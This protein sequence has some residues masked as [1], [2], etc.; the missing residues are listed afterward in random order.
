MADLIDLVASH[1]DASTDFSLRR[2][3]AAYITAVIASARRGKRASVQLAEQ[4]VRSD[5]AHAFSFD[6]TGVATL[7]ADGKTWC[8]GRFQTRSIG[9]L[10]RAVATAAHLNR[11]ILFTATVFNIM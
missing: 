9:E 8:A 11:S 6:A 4:V 10:R 1:A 2:E 5:P 7:V 3:V